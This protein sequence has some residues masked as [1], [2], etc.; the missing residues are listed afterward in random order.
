MQQEVF[1]K[2]DTTQTSVIALTLDK[3]TYDTTG[4]GTQHII[5]T[6]GQETTMRQLI[7]ADQHPGMLLNS[8]EAVNAACKR[9]LHD[10]DNDNAMWAFENWRGTWMQTLLRVLT[11]PVVVVRM[12][13]LFSWGTV[14]L[15]RA[16]RQDERERERGGGVKEG[17]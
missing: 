6:N 12:V 16:V 3:Y 15:W 2:E 10:F 1:T 14:D 4:R 8:G 13:W 5:L 17:V 7:D 9:L 11:L